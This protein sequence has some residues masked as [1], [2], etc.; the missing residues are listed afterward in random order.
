MV[1]FWWR[2]T[3]T[4]LALTRPLVDITMEKFDSGYEGMLMEADIKPLARR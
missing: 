2:F 4:I 1:L 3:S